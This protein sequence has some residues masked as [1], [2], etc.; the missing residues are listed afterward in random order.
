MYV[1]PIHAKHCLNAVTESAGCGAA[2]LIRSIEPVWGVEKMR[3][4]RGFEELRRLTRGPAMLCQALAVDRS[5]D[6]IDI[7]E[8]QTFCIADCDS[9][10][11]TI[12][13]TAR[14]G[15]S[16]AKDLPLRFIN[17]SSQFLSR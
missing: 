12:E 6:G 17:R 8:D 3:E 7:V 5:H 16:K 15:I 13:A 10:Q 14:I 4:R 9:D 2:V 11:P 1:Y